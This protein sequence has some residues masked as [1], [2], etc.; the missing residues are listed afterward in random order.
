ML[1][2]GRVFFFC[3]G[4]LERANYSASIKV[5]HQEGHTRHKPAFQR[6]NVQTATEV[7]GPIFFRLSYVYLL[8]GGYI[9]Y[10]LP[11]FTYASRLQPLK[12][13]EELWLGYPGCFPWVLNPT[14]SAP[15][16]I[17]TH[18]RAS[19]MLHMWLVQHHD[20]VQREPSDVGDLTQLGCPRKLLN[21]RWVITAIYPIY[22]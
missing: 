15:L 7:Q 10:I 21:G 16:S 14:V 4:G 19:D 5:C 17:P 22:K 18:A 13:A 11:S 3:G 8:G 1:A 2:L 12:I 20:Y 9:L 6:C